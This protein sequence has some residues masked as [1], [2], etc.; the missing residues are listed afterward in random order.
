MT[1]I[2]GRSC[3]FCLDLDLEWITFA[4]ECIRVKKLDFFWSLFKLQFAADTYDH[5]GTCRCITALIVIH[6]VDPRQVL[7]FWWKQEE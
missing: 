3:N 4:K 2:A 1:S 6:E 7:V 5:V